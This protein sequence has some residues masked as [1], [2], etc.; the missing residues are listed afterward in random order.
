[1]KR[2]TTLRTW[3]QQLGEALSIADAADAVGTTPLRLAR[4]AASGKLRVCRFE[5]ADGRVFHMVRVQDLLDYRR[6][7]AAATAPLTRA[8]MCRAFARM[9]AS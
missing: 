8:A 7:E 6:R 5:A 1:M 2:Q 9:A 4:A 3:R